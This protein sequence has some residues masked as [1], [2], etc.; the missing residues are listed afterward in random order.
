MALVHVRASVNNYY[1]TLRV[2]TSLQLSFCLHSDATFSAS[3]GPDALIF[4]GNHGQEE[5]S[6]REIRLIDQLD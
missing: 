6:L 3:L 1:S 4:L 5:S 2:Y